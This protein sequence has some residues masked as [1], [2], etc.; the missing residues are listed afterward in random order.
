MYRFNN[1]YNHVCCKE[2]ME[3]LINIKYNSYEGY[4]RDTICLEAKEKIKEAIDCEKAK[5]HFLVGGTQTNRIVISSSLRCYESVISSE[6]GHIFA[7]ETGAIEST[8]HKVEIIKSF[9]GKLDPNLLI[10]KI[11]EYENNDFKSHITTP[12]VVYTSLP[13]ELGAIY[14]KKELE[15]IFNIC[16]EHSLY[17]YLDGAR[18]G[19]GL[20]AK[21]CDIT[22]KDLPKLCDAFYIGGTKCGA[23]FGEAVVLINENLK[24]GFRQ[25]IKQTGGLLAKGFLLG[26]QFKVLF[27]NNLYMNITKDAVD[28]AIKIKKAFLE[29]DIE[30]Y[31]DSPTNQQF[32]L[33]SENHYNILKEKYIFEHEG[34]I[35]SKHQIR[36]CTDFMTK[37]E[38][39]ESLINDIKI[40]P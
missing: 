35:N 38:E 5:I 21:E 28:Y 20:N 23:M 3:E 39:V 16:K 18:L 37:E 7:H 13:T 9:D 8:G 17:F 32:I 15:E 30:L 25:M 4:G 12:R 27:T 10:K 34:I 19:Y 6:I 14:T 31:Y 36:I 29:K 11:E 40:L 22:L 24:S 33:L 1:D 26:L 2:I